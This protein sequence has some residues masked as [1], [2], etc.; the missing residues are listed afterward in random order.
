MCR[1]WY[2]PSVQNGDRSWC[3]NWYAR[4]VQNGAS[5]GAVIGTLVACRIGLV[6]LP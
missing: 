4:S 3:R 2:A 1:N 6:L 5:P